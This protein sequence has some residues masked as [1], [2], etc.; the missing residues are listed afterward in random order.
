MYRIDV[1]TASDS[2]PSPTSPGPNVDGYFS[3]GNPGLA[4]PATVVPA[5]W[6][7]MIQEEVAGLV[8]AA[9]LSLDKADRGQLSDAVAAMI[10]DALTLTNKVDKA[11]D[12]MTG[13]LLMPQGSAS[14]P[15]LARDGDANNGIWFPG[16]D[17]IEIVTAGTGRLRVDASGRVLTGALTSPATGYGNAG[18]VSLPTGGVIRAKNTLSAWVNF[19]GTG[20]VAIRDAFNVSS[21]TDNAVADYTLNF[22]NALGNANYAVCGA[23]SPA[24]A[25]PNYDTLHFGING[26]N[27]MNTG[28][29]RVCWSVNSGT[30]TG[31]D[32]S[33]DPPHA[34][35][36][37]AGGH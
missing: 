35:V 36:M 22:A 7:N 34:L 12:T 32:N 30:G 9:G 5:E 2:L 33:A 4:V 27:V 11:G 18:D 8:E 1:A 20:T 31:D 10:A 15:A 14:N 13:P 24:F 6:L 25:A 23:A 19:N 28:N 26:N 17:I 16:T 21:I 29:V 37:V 3:D